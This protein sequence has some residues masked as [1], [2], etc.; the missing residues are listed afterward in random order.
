MLQTVEHSALERIGEPTSEAPNVDFSCQVECSHSRFARASI[1]HAAD[2]DIAEAASM[3]WIVTAISAPIRE[4]TA[5]LEALNDTDLPTDTK[6]DWASQRMDTIY[7][8]FSNLPIFG[9]WTGL[10]YSLA[11]KTPLRLFLLPTFTLKLECSISFDLMVD[12]TALS[13]S[14][15]T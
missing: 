13:R 3:N 10:G 6:A 11:T 2:T 7:S 14:S 15:V 1:A 8:G 4:Q 9:Q 12:R 5:A